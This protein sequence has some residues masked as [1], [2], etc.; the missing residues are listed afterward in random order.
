MEGG[1]E[2][3]EGGY[4]TLGDVL[5]GARVRRRSLVVV[6]PDAARLNRLTRG[7]LGVES[8]AAITDSAV[9]EEGRARRAARVV[10]QRVLVSWPVFRSLDPVTR[11]RIVTHELTHAALAGTT[12][13]RTPAWLVEGIAL[14]TSGDRRLAEAA[15]ALERRPRPSLSA[16]AA[17]D[18]IAR[19]SGVRQS[20]A[21]AFASAAAAYVAERFGEKG[22]L[23]LYEVYNDEALSGAAGDPRTTGRATRAALGIGRRRLERD[24]R[25]WLQSGGGG[26]A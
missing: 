7:I 24:L 17:P 21:Y 2:A 9:R 15:R 11:S 10:S 1:G 22:L 25:A 26:G 5:G 12:S 8:L 19:T 6:A 20:E 23:D 3:L 16:L 13:G 18:G 14:H 4:A